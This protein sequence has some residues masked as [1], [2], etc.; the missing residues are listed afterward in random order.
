MK[1]S[2]RWPWIDAFKGWGMLLIVVGHVWALQDISTFYKWLFAFH[3]PIFFYAAGLT[4]KLGAG[5][6]W[7]MLQRRAPALLKPYL[8][9]GLLGYAFYLLGFAAAQAAGLQLQQFDYGLFRPLWGVLYGSV[10]DGLLVNSPIWFLP[11]LL[12]ASGLVYSLNSRISSA[13]VRYAVC[14]TLLV[15]GA[16]L[17]QQAKMPWSFSSALCA[18]VFMQ[19]GVDHQRS[20]GLQPWSRQRLWLLLPVCFLLSLW[21]PLNGD[22]GLAGPTVNNPVL[23]VL[24]ALVGIGLSLALTQL[25]AHRLPVLIWLGK[26]S[27]GVLVFHMLAIKGVKV[28]LSMVFGTP[29]QTL[30]NDV[31]WGLTVLVL[32]GGL[33]V[34]AVLIV[35]R[36]WPWALGPTP[37][38][39]AQHH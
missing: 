10:G 25:I 13:T 23:F 32:A 22:V 17:A 33:T 27:M 38:K 12:I 19:M 28:V 6:T 16:A 34:V 5:S 29:V 21:A 4:L 30:E 2:G 8:I 39:P 15:A 36:W 9:F 31:L 37:M 18:T 26:N 14:L 35:Q 7:Q 20:L 11:A 3:V 1:T 24:F